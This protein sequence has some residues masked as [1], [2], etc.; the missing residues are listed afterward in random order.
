MR[1]ALG[2]VARREA[3]RLRGRRAFGGSLF[4]A[5]LERCGSGL[6][7]LDVLQS[8]RIPLGAAELLDFAGALER[9]GEVP[10]AHPAFGA[11]VD[12]A[13]ALAPAGTDGTQTARLLAF[14]ARANHKRGVQVLLPFWEAR[15]SGTAPEEA[16]AA[17]FY[18]AKV[19]KFLLPEKT[20]LEFIRWAQPRLPELG[21]REIYRGFYALC[22]MNVRD[23]AIRGFARAAARQVQAKLR[24]DPRGAEEDLPAR[25]VLRLAW[26]FARCEELDAALFG[27]L[28]AALRG[29]LDCLDYHELKAAYHVFTQP[30]QV[31]GRKTLP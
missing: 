5:E 18:A 17:V 9:C 29:R 4:A 24:R 27:V 30:R 2:R 21:L 12:R 3:L 16:I 1:T 22:R 23:P 26:A 19:R 25:D 13:A 10:R 20:L 14:F 11:L 15:L 8:T 6:A 31:D 28:A 7:V